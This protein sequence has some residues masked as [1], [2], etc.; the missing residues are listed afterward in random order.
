MK[1]RENK[2]IYILRWNP[3]ELVY[4]CV[5]GKLKR[6]N[7]QRRVV[8]NKGRVIDRYIPET[9]QIVLEQLWTT[10]ANR[11]GL[12]EDEKSLFKF[13]YYKLRDIELNKE[14]EFI[15]REKKFITVTN[16]LK[17]IRDIISK[18]SDNYNKCD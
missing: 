15:R 1:Y 3:S 13:I 12:F 18:V 4:A 6:V 8:N 5:K 17:H 2:P 11:Y 14:D 9:G 7:G 10:N 16:E